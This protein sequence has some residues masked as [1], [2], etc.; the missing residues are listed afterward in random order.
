MW[1][2]T[3]QTFWRTQIL[4]NDWGTASLLSWED[5]VPQMRIW[6]RN[7]NKA[8]S[9]IIIYSCLQCGENLSAQFLKWME[10]S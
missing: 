2:G 3:Q 10:F 7:E 8:Q 9:L 1:K 5:S 4:H 6:F